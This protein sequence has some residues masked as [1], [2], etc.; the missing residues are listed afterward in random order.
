MTGS[1]KKSPFW[2]EF[3]APKTPGGI[4]FRV[5]A[6]VNGITYYSNIQV[7]TVLP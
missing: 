3:R 6:V 1:D 4:L 2:A 5:H 7:V